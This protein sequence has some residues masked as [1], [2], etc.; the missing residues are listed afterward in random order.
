MKRSMIL[1]VLAVLS[2]SCIAEDDVSAHAKAEPPS[3]PEPGYGEPR[4]PFRSL[5]L[6]AIDSAVKASEALGAGA[7]DTREDLG[8][9]YRHSGYA[10]AASFFENTAREVKGEE[11][12]LT[13]GGDLGG[14]GGGE[15][16]MS[17]AA[18]QVARRVA[19][20]ISSGA[21]QQAVDVARSEIERNGST[22]QLAVQWAHATIALATETPQAVK[23]AAREVAIRVM[24]TSLEER[25]PRPIGVD[26]RADGYSLLARSFL[27]YGDRVSA[28]TAARLALLDLQ[29]Q[30]PNSQFRIASEK[31]LTRIIEMTR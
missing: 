27:I 24:L 22:L 14:W 31:R 28:R 2:L 11:L 17:G 9:L 10:G 29:K 7:Y 3:N 30:D 23:P 15:R 12:V 4:P 21:Y 13:P 6:D 25:V 16:E 26:S 18:Q 8:R 19:D 1:A 5:S 20:L